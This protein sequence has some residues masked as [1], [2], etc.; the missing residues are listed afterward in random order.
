MGLTLDAE[1]RADAPAPTFRPGAGASSCV[2]VGVEPRSSSVPQEGQ[3][4]LPSV[5][6]LAQPGQIIWGR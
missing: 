2:S 5:T 4:R 1:V 3:K 6:S